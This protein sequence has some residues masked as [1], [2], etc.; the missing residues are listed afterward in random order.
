L[1]V[2]DFGAAEEGLTSENS[3]VAENAFRRFGGDRPCGGQ[4][5]C[6]SQ[7]KISRRLPRAPFSLQIFPALRLILIHCSTLN[8]GFACWK[9]QK[10]G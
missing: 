10:I 2:E 1:G 6:D 5:K 9:I 4:R 7:Q 8:N 3:G